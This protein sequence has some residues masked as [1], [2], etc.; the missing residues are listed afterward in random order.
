MIAK[1]RRGFTQ[2][3]AMD[4]Y[5]LTEKYHVQT[6][7]HDCRL[8][9][10]PAEW[11]RELAAV[12]RLEADVNNGAYLQFLGNWGLETYF[13]ASRALR[14]IGAVS[15]SRIIDACQ[16]LVEE[17]I[18]VRNA[19]RE[20]LQQLELG[21]YIDQQGKVKE[22]ASSPLPQPARNRILELS[23]EFMSYPDNISELGM[24]HY[25]QFLDL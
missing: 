9:S 10:L 21:Q 22:V 7:E 19:T 25:R 18:D 24:R 17:H 1:Y 13:Y 23:Y 14:I 5:K 12:W 2:A 8:S 3:Q 20:Q 16:A 4:W 15:M 11:Q 6:F